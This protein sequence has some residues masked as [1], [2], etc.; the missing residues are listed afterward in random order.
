M[1]INAD[2][3]A[4]PRNYNHLADA[5]LSGTIQGNEVALR[6]DDDGRVDRVYTLNVKDKWSLIQDSDD[7]M[8]YASIMYTMIEPNRRY[9]LSFISE[10]DS[11]PLCSAFTSNPDIV[12]QKGVGCGK[13]VDVMESIY[14]KDYLYYTTRNNLICEYET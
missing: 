7:Y 1:H 3:S 4:W 14:G 13:S 8:K 5:S 9:M 2:V 12:S 6:L 10:A 11:K